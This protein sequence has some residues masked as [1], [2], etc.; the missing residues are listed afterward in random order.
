MNDLTIK[1]Q[2]FARRLVESKGNQ[3]RAYIATYGCSVSSA[4]PSA[5]RL[6]RNVHIYEY[7]MTIIDE[8]K[9]L[10]ASI[11][12]A[13]ARLLNAK[14]LIRVRGGSIQVPDDKVRMG[15][16]RLGYKLHGIKV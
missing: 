2:M 15:S 4:A 13:H 14:K 6:L 1:H 16:V 9:P 12:R 7:V 5:S 3:T 8:D 10:L 11:M